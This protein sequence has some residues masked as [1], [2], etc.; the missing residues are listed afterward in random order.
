MADTFLRVLFSKDGEKY[1]KQLFFRASIAKLGK[2]RMGSYAQIGVYRV[3]QYDLCA[4]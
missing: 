3:K 2:Y 1:G 4:C